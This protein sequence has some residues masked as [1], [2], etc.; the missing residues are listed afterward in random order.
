MRP[1][2]LRAN[3]R[4]DER[5]KE[6]IHSFINAERSETLRLFSEDIYIILGKP[7]KFFKK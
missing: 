5:S 1:V 3:F 7:K 2:F 6:A 4:A